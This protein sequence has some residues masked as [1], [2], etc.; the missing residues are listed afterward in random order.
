MKSPTG[1]PAFDALLVAQL[2]HA[3]GVLDAA[4]VAVRVAPE[5]VVDN[6]TFARIATVGHTATYLDTD[7]PL[8]NVD[9][10]D[11]F[12]VRFQVRNAD[13]A[14]SLSPRLQWSTA[15]STA[16]ADV[17]VGGRELDVPLYVGTEWR[18]LP[19]GSGTLPGPEQEVIP[20]SGVRVHDRDDGAQLPVP[21]EHLMGAQQVP[22][23][24]LA[25]DSY[26]EIEFTVRTTAAV[27][28]RQAYAFRLVDSGHAIVGAVEAHAVAVSQPELTLS[29]GQRDGIPVGPPVDATP[30]PVSMMDAPQV[31]PATAAG[32]WPEPGGA[33][34]YRLAIALPTTPATR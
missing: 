33:P 4:S 23:V 14:V 3:G 29:P 20:A 10:Y 22:T 17:P 28:L 34:I 13:V 31:V 5:I 9:R 7:A 19:G 1:R 27:V 15:G 12:R 24:P 32:T 18:P 21:G 25:G 6:V 11:T 30:T 2:M 8:D 16:F 26:T